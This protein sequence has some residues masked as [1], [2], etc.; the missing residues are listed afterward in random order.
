MNHVIDL[1]SATKYNGHFEDSLLQMV[2]HVS[3][4]NTP[5]ISSR[6]AFCLTIKAHVLN[7]LVAQGLSFDQAFAQVDKLSVTE[8]EVAE[9]APVDHRDQLIRDTVQVL[10]KEE[11]PCS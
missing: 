11:K 9:L 3:D 4:K 10:G 2:E 5:M 6:G 7:G 1:Q 8:W